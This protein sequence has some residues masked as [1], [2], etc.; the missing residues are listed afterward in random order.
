ME[1]F[2]HRNVDPNRHDYWEILY[3]MKNPM[4]YNDSTKNISHGFFRYT[5]DFNKLKVCV[6]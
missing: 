3:I 1:I 4:C 5:F 6:S 2:L